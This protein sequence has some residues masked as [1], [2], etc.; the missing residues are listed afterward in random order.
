MAEPFALAGATRVD[1]ALADPAQAPL[2]ISVLREFIAPTQL[3]V[4]VGIGVVEYLASRRRR[5]RR[6]LPGAHAPCSWR[7]ATAA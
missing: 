1:G 6:L 3:R 4:G 5:P 7:R 2:C